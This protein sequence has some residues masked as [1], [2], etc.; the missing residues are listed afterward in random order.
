MDAKKGEIISQDEVIKRIADGGDIR[1]FIPLQNVKELA[2]EIHNVDIPSP[3]DI[4]KQQPKKAKQAPKDT[5]E[6]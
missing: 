4:K 5:K 1:R 3:D 2:D 6:K